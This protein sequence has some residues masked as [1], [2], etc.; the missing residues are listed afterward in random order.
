M[1]EAARQVAAEEELDIDAD[2]ITPRKLGCLLKKGRFGKREAGAGVRGWNIKRAEFGRWAAS[3]GLGAGK[4]A[5]Q[6]AGE[7]SPAGQQD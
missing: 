7:A 2:H 3:L 4:N 1:V 5:L 6:E